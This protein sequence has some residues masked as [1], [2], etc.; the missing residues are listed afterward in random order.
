MLVYDLLF[1]KSFRAGSPDIIGIEHLQHVRARISHQSAD[2]QHHERDHR[3]DQ[4]FSIV[5]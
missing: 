3:Q 2:T 4:V 5:K 1:R